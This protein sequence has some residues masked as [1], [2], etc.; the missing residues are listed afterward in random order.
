MRKVRELLLVS[1][2]PLLN[3]KGINTASL[4]K[5]LV[6]VF[7]DKTL[8]SAQQGS[9]MRTIFKNTFDKYTVNPSSMLRY[10][11]RRRKKESLQK[12]LYS[13]TNLRQQTANAAN[14]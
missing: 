4:E 12:Y 5:M 10:A 11:D 1:E 2:A 3:I 6:D 8:F 7:C 14:I 9:E 13:I